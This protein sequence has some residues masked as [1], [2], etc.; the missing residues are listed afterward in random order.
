MFTFNLAGS[1]MWTVIGV[2]FWRYCNEHYEIIIIIINNNSNISA[3]RFSILMYTWQGYEVQNKILCVWSNES[4]ENEGLSEFKNVSS[5]V[6]MVT[7]P[8]IVTIDLL[9]VMWP[10]VS[11]CLWGYRVYPGYMA[12]RVP[13]FLFVIASHRDFHVFHGAEIYCWTHETGFHGC[14]SSMVTTNCTTGLARGI[15]LASDIKK[16]FHGY[17]F[18]VVTMVLGVKLDYNLASTDYRISKVT[19]LR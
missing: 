14:R 16:G 5:L 10:P 15:E 8:T 18:S 4:G 3:V 9:W 17:G 13:W 2:Y 1:R 11:P 12:I 7:M 19:I 6:A